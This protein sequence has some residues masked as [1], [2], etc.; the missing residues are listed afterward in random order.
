MYNFI[1]STN[2]DKLKELLFKLK[3]DLRHYKNKPNF[4]DTIEILIDK[5]KIIENLLNNFED[6]LN[7]EKNYSKEIKI[8]EKYL[9]KFEKKYIEKIESSDGVI[10]EYQKKY[11]F[12]PN[13]KSN[14]IS[15]YFEDKFRQQNF[16]EIIIDNVK[17]FEKTFTKEILDDIKYSDTC[18]IIVNK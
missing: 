3:N 11:N 18:V 9:K 15:E 13:K 6:Q 12:Y 5:E 8:L 2:R 16:D 14:R 4:I 1:L 10:Y 17:R 7:D